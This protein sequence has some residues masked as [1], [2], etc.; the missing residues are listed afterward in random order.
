MSIIE[1]S[2]F[3]LLLSLEMYGRAYTWLLLGTYSNNWW[4][5]HA[6][7]SKRN[8]TAALDTTILTDLLPLSTTGEMTV[9]GIVRV[10]ITEASSTV[11]FEREMCPSLLNRSLNHIVF[12]KIVYASG[13]SQ[14]VLFTHLSFTKVTLLLQKFPV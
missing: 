14:H 3:F 2:F 6:P 10:S 7:C 12:H 1:S 9:S 8:L 4:M 11:L 5:R 13:I